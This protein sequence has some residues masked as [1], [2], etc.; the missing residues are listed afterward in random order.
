MAPEVESSDSARYS[1]ERLLII[2]ASK[3]A[4]TR[5]FVHPPEKVLDRDLSGYAT[6]QA[7]A[8]FKLIRPRSLRSI[9]QLAKTNLVTGTTSVD[10]SRSY[11]VTFGAT[12][13]AG[14]DVSL[15][16]AKFNQINA[17][18]NQQ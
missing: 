11:M 5:V 18:C 10:L 16:I 9:L 14:E 4:R 3:S 13:G 2:V 12:V 17:A 8:L 1:Q 7:L 6:Y 15:N